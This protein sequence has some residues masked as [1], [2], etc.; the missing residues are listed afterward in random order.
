MRRNRSQTAQRRSHHGLTGSRLATCECGALRQSHRACV[1]CG[2]YDGKIVV[3]V[4][5]EQKR[6]ARRSKRREKELR[7]S[8]Q[9]TT[10]KPEDKVAAT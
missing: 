10:Q 4:V 9:E 3:D 2:K 7:E 5:A 8:G 1:S 6:D